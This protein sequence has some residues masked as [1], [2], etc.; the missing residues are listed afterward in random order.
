MGQ[1][2]ATVH[3]GYDIITDQIVAIK[4]EPI[5]NNSVSSLPHEYSILTQL[6]GP[7]IIRFPRPLWFGREGS[8]RVMVLE[9][10]GSSLDKVIHTSS[11]G[12]FELYHV[13]RLGLQMVSELLARN[14]RQ[15]TN[16]TCWA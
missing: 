7:G 2:S 8:Y 16:T 14:V 13:A 11:P 1:N 10:L 12:G 15:Q 6:Q 5:T 9:N 3:S 4:L